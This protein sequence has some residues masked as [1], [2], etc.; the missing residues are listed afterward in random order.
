MEFEWDPEKAERNLRKHR[1]SFGEATTVFG[2]WLGVTV[3]DPDHSTDEPR[4]LMIGTSSRQRKLIVSY[5][6]RGARYRIIS[7]REM[8]PRERKAYERAGKGN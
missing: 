7:A 2:D 1:V 3:N 6:E 8:T 5:A 4:F